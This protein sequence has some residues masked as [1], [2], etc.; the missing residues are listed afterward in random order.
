[1]SSQPLR[2]T[3]H[4]TP[5]RPLD[6]LKIFVTHIKEALMPHPSGKSSRELIMSELVAL[7]DGGQLGVDFVEV[8]RGDRICECDAVQNEARG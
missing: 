4:L 6:G 3:S 1:M 2:H 5:S 7:E 8:R